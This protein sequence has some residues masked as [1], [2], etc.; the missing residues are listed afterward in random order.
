MNLARHN[1][2]THKFVVI[3][4]PNLNRIVIY[5]SQSPSRQGAGENT[6]PTGGPQ[7]WQFD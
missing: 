2:T 1:R 6:P 3:H 4:H 7:L 5:R